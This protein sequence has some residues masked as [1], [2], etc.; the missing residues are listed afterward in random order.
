MLDI[1]WK[2]S[3]KEL[4]QFAALCL[5]IFGGIGAWGAYRHGFEGHAKWFLIAG[6][7]VGVPGLIVPMFRALLERF[8]SDPTPVDPVAVEDT[9]ERWDLV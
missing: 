1:N 5:V 3:T 2:P 8:G 6:A 9:L 4:R 7:A